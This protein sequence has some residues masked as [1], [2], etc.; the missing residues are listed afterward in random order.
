[1]FL[2]LLG[3]SVPIGFGTIIGLAIWDSMPGGIPEG[4]QCLILLGG[5]GIGIS[6]LMT[7]GD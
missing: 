4:L 5:F 3:L 6:A 1:M 7:A 2:I